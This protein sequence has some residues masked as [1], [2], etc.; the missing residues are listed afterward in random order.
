MNNSTGVVQSREHARRQRQTVLHDELT[1]LPNRVLFASRLHKAISQSKRW[2]QRLAVVRLDL[3]GLEAVNALHGH[4]VGDRVIAALARKMKRSLRKNDILA[5][6]SGNG[7]AAL[8]ADLDETQSAVP[9]VNRLLKAAAEPVPAGESTVQLWASV[10]FSFF[11]QAEDADADKLLRQAGQALRQ[12]REAGTAGCAFFSAAHQT[13]TVSTPE[14]FARIREAFA[15]N[16]FVLYY[17]PKVN[18]V[19]G[20]VVGVEVLVRWQHPE[21]GL[22]LPV[23][24]LPL[25]ED[26]SMGIELDEWVIGATLTQ[27]EAWLD[28]GL[29]LPVSI[30][31]GSKQ[32]Q[33]PG[34][35]SDLAA[36]LA[37]HPRIPPSRLELDIL[38]TG[39]LQDIDQ[40]I[41]LLTEC[42]Q[43]GVTFALD[44]FGTGHLSLSELKRLP[45]DVLKIDP[46]LVRDILEDP[47]ELTI[48]EGVLGLVAAFG[49]RPVAEGVETIEQG[50]MLLRLGCEQALGYGIAQPMPANEFP[51]WVA[52]WRPDPRWIEALQV[53]VDERPLL[54]AGVEHRAWVAEIEAYLRGEDL[55]EPR[56][57][58]HQC[59]FGAWLYADGPGGR[60]SQPGLQAIIALHWRI[61]ALATGMVKFGTQ[62]RAAEGMARLAE[63]KELVDKLADLLNDFGQKG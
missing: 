3:E 59:Q 14:D 4:S 55:R 10:G 16:E 8:L 56:V 6:L 36:L 53:T 57:S 45:L 7:F 48:L 13:G 5:R 11:P 29:D 54:H 22:L 38:E 46:S 62:G 63:L 20:T 19:Q 51:E 17:Q 52:A 39:P 32:M 24:F 12:A 2:G 25:I 47:K 43:I 1:G 33:Q 44:D 41:G 37:A 27:M 21:R 26:D 31:I 60:S 40:L 50:L 9:M 61:H 34:F 42:R 15:A 35:A 49:C 18:M 58:R 30:N 23:E 28:A